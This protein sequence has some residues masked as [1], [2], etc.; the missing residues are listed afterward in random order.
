MTALIGRVIIATVL[1]L[2]GPQRDGGWGGAAREQ[3]ERKGGEMMRW[4]GEN[5]NERSCRCV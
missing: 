3:W 1:L 5:K 4:G 2:D